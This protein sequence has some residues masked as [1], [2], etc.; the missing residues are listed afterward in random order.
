MR[1]RG[2]YL[3]HSVAY[4]FLEKHYS[5]KFKSGTCHSLQIMLFLYFK[6]LSHFFCS[7]PPSVLC[8]LNS[9]HFFTPLT[10]IWHFTH[11]L[12]FC[13][14]H[15]AFIFKS[16][17]PKMMLSSWSIFHLNK[18]MHLLFLMRIHSGNIHKK[19]QVH[20]VHQWIT[21]LDLL[22]TQHIFLLRFGSFLFYSFRIVILRGRHYTLKVLLFYKYRHYLLKQGEKNLNM[23]CLRE[24]INFPPQT[25]W[26]YLYIKTWKLVILLAISGMN[27]NITQEQYFIF[28]SLEP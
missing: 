25:M 24:V 21:S 19:R 9:F 7:F 5:S 15:L 12:N 4:N 16:D 14:M 2:P 6:Q 11:I 28:S 3:F 23:R 8:T 18:A 26:I 13:L 20:Y 27:V 10:S 17:V 1:E 22:E